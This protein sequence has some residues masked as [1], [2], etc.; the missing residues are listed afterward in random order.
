[1]TATSASPVS[2][3]RTVGSRSSANAASEAGRERARR[4]EER[5]ADHPTNR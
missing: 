1:M 3:I 5:E 4:D 2:C